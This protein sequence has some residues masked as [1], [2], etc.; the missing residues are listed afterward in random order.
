MN[1]LYADDAPFAGGLS[2][3]LAGPTPR[4]DYVPSWRP[5]ALDILK[6][7]G[8][9]GTVLV[10]ERRDWSVKFD[11][12]DQVEWE[13]AGLLH[14]SIIVIWLPRDLATMPAFTTNVEFGY[15]L[16]EKPFSV[17]Y[18]RPSE[19]PKNRYL[20]WLYTK[21]T[22]Q[23]PYDCLFDTL[24]YAEGAALI[25]DIFVQRRLAAKG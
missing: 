16:A 5:E 19:N 7:M 25:E 21:H 17:R 6:D 12:T 2:I 15:W 14:A 24:F 20:D 4:S 10:P 1:V 13:Y 3:F 9:A 18:G 22:H 11:Y 8:F 23:Q